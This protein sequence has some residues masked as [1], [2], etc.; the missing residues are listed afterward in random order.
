MDDKDNKY[1]MDDEDNKD[2]KNEEEEVDE[3]VFF[4]KM[5]KISKY[6]SLPNIVRLDQWKQVSDE[7]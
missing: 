4:A 5:H 7:Y 3:E 1:N 6:T 2:N